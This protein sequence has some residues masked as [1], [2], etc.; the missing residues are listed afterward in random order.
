VAGT[1]LQQ[2]LV[3]QSVDLPALRLLTRSTI[4]RIRASPPG[5]KNRVMT[6]R[7][8][9]VKTTGKRRT[10]KEPRRALGLMARGTGSSGASLKMFSIHS[11]VVLDIPIRRSQRKCETTPALG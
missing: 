8:S 7:I 1:E 9:L 11:N 5:S 3:Q 2:H 10:F 4:L 6:R